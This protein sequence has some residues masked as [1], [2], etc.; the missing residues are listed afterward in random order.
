LEK[1]I[2]QK[3]QLAFVKLLNSKIRWSILTS[4]CGDLSDF[5]QAAAGANSELN[6]NRVHRVTRTHLE[7]LLV[8]IP[9]QIGG[10]RRHTDFG[11]NSKQPLLR[12]WLAS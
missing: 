11:K 5:F 12:S 6:S 3:P 2:C 9:T 4:Q 8:H 7:H 1:S 10:L